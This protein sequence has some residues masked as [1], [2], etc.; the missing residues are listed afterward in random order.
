MYVLFSANNQGLVLSN[1]LSCSSHNIK[2]DF[3]AALNILGLLAQSV[4]TC[5]TADPGFPSSISARSH[6]FV[7]L[8]HEI[9]SSVILLLPLI[10]EGLL[11]FTS[12]SMCTGKPLS[13][14]F[15]EKSVV[16]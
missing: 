12:E 14:A 13:Q 3:H 2:T 10:Q 1:L 7:E 9:I 15:P 11:S 16:R 8:D 5:L 6:T 4:I